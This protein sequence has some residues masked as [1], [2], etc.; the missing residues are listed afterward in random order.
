[1]CM[2]SCGKWDFAALSLASS[3]LKMTDILTDEALQWKTFTDIHEERLTL[4][5]RE[6]ESFKSVTHIYAG[7]RAESTV[8]RMRSGAEHQLP[9]KHSEF[10]AFMESC[11]PPSS[12]VQV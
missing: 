9:M 6:I 4:D 10:K 7:Q 1:M 5:L 8:V 12:S 11:G 3:A 2:K